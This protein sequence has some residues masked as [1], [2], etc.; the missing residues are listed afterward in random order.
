MASLLTDP[1]LD[2]TRA[3]AKSKLAKLSMQLKPQSQEDGGEIDGDGTPAGSDDALQHRYRLCG[4]VPNSRAFAMRCPRAS[5]MADGEEPMPDALDWV[6]FLIEFHG[7]EISTRVRFVRPPC[8]GWL[9]T[10]NRLST[11]KMRSTWRGPRAT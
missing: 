8:S 5:S 9:T 4:V 3:S 1:D 2:E 6:W 11:R 10:G 7:V